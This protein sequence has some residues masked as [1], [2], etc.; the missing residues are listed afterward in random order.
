ME[1]TIVLYPIIAIG[2]I[3]SMVE[4]GK[5]ILRHYRHRLS[6]TVLIAEG[7]LDTP[8][9]TAFLCHISKNTHSI[10]FHR[11]PFL[12]NNPSPN[13]NRSM[14]RTDFIHLNNPN[15]HQALQTISKISRI[16]A[17]VID[18][19]S[20]PAL[21]VSS[22]L[23]IP[24]YY[25]LAGGSV[26]LSFLLY[27]PIIHDQTTKSFKDIPTTHL[28]FPG[29]PPMPA[30][31]L[32]E[33]VQDRELQVYY[34]FLEIGS[35]LCKS[36]GIIVNTFECLE[37]TVIKAIIDGLCV[38]DA[39]TP[40]VY[41]IGPLITSPNNR[42]GEGETVNQCLS[43]LDGQ[44]SQSVV[45]LNFGSRG[46]FSAAQVREIAIG[47]EK[48]RQ[49]FLWVLRE[50]V[51]EDNNKHFAVEHKDPDLEALLPEVCAGVPMVAW[52]LY[53]EQ[54]INKAFL[55]EE[56]KFAMAMEELEDGLVSATE[57]EKRVLALMESEEGR[58]LRERSRKMKEE[59][60]SVWSECGSSMIAFAKLVESWISQ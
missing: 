56:M 1:G 58:V 21:S 5:L 17:F 2:H 10:N 16:R 30:S 48:S 9:A 44:P 49:R 52:P 47:L 37:S 45:F 35:N 19:F 32:P 15:L 33:P 18:I 39:P 6:V 54:Y 26:T 41:C 60:M 23:G 3:V 4:L 22:D 38:P 7:P 13:G 53:A 31:Y 25:F 51:S 29:L 20:T 28:H 14:I 8:D 42:S 59:A 43:W 34:D 50:P 55:V 36:K 57:V 40:P 46:V 27:L 24:T 12:S 11:L